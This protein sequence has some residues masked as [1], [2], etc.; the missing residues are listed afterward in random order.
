[1]RQAILKLMAAAIVGSLIMWFF[2]QPQS[3][4][5]SVDV[6]S[7]ALHRH[8]RNA[9]A[10]LDMSLNYLVR[11]KSTEDVST[12]QSRFVAMA[13][14]IMVCTNDQVRLGLEDVETYPSIDALRTRIRFV[15]SK[16]VQW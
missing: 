4:P 6:D 10:T 3:K 8:V 15:Q 5:A 12:V 13:P 2:M 7:A 11:S 9:C 14:L 1:M 16:M